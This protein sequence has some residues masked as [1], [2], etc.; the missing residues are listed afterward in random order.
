MSR[1]QGIPRRQG[2]SWTDQTTVVYRG[3]HETDGIKQFRNVQ[4]AATYIHRT[5]CDDTALNAPH[6]T[7][8]AH[9]TTSRVGAKDQ[10]QVFHGIRHATDGVRQLNNGSIRNSTGRKID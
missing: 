1:H 7:T 5:Y 10:L 6:E 9:L 2:I 3:W 8:K 4:I